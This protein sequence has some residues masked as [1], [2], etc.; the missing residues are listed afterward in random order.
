MTGTKVGGIRTSIRNKERHGEDFYKKIGAKGG[1]R[2]KREKY[3]PRTKTGQFRVGRASR[4]R[5]VSR[6]QAS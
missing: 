1:K 2:G 4:P 3:Q 6:S 5:R